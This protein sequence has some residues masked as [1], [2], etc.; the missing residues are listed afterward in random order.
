MKVCMCSSIF[1]TKHIALLLNKQRVTDWKS[2]VG[3]E[4]KMDTTVFMLH[5]KNPGHLIE[6]MLRVNN[7]NMS[8]IQIKLKRI[9]FLPVLLACCHASGA[10]KIIQLITEILYVS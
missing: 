7:D 10:M 4:F 2:N 6:N 9:D 3:I 8:F 5:K 1:K